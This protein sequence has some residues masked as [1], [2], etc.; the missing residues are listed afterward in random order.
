VTDEELHRRFVA[1]LRE[2]LLLAQQHGL[3]LTATQ[4]DSLLASPVALWEN[5]AAVLRNRR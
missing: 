5:L 4:I 2:C 1:V 3:E